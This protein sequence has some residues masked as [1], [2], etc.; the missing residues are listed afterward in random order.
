MTI[1]AKYPGKCS[2][3]GAAI[4]V[5]QQIEWEKGKGSA[6][7]TCPVVERPKLRSSF[8]PEDLRSLAAYAAKVKAEQA[9]G[10]CKVVNHFPSA[11]PRIGL[12]LEMTPDGPIITS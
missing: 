1:I 7:A 11:R 9:A 6:H 8:T 3:C 2:V 12:R 10:Q 4:Q 5:G